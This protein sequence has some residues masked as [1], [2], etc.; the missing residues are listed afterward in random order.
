MFS[1]PHPGNMQPRFAGSNKYTDGHMNARNACA[2]LV[3]GEPK[4]ADE[5]WF[6]ITQSRWQDK[7]K[8][9]RWD[10]RLAA[11][12]GIH[13]ACSAAHVQ[14]TVVHWMTT[15]E[16]DY[17]FARPSAGQRR[18]SPRRGAPAPIPEDDVDTGGVRQIGELSVHRESIRRVLSENPYSLATILEALL[19][20]LGPETTPGKRGTEMEPEAAD[21]VLQEV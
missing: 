2:C 3:C 5:R 11:Q 1:Q 8:I 21:R 13:H 10:D 19:S 18:A 12:P 16:L 14:Q 20:A 15:G 4:A 9:L 17:P 6:L 7:L